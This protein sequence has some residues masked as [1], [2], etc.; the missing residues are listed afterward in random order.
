MVFGRKNTGLPHQRD[1]KGN[2]TVTVPIPDNKPGKAP[3]FG[4]LLAGKC[5]QFQ[6]QAG[7]EILDFI[8]QNRGPAAKLLLKLKDLFIRAAFFSLPRDPA[9]NHTVKAILDTLS[10][11]GI[12]DILVA[13]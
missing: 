6:R 9:A 10:K 11:P 3:E 13:L 5:N 8:I 2:V 4:Q 12:R 1:I 7:A